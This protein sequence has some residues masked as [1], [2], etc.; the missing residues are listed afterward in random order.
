[1]INRIDFMFRNFMKTTNGT[2]CTF[3]QMMKVTNG[4]VYTFRQ[5]MK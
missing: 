5:M 2:V 4:S 1:M 3:R